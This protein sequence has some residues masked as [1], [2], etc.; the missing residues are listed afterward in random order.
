MGFLLMLEFCFRQVEQA[1]KV[2]Q[3]LLVNI[4]EIKKKFEHCLSL[5][6]NTCMAPVKS[7]KTFP[8]LLLFRSML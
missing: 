5:C 1:K 6:G 7:E 4:I 2:R 3:P 8:P